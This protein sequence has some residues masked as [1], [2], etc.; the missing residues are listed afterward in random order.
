MDRLP[1]ENDRHFSWTGRFYSKNC[2]SLSFG[3]ITEELGHELPL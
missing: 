2:F 1:I 3:R